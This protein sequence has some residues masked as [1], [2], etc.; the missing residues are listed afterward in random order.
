VRRGSGKVQIATC[1]RARH[2]TRPARHEE[3][4]L[5]EPRVCGDRAKVVLPSPEIKPTYKSRANAPGAEV[6]QVHGRFHQAKIQTV[7]AV[8]VGSQRSQ[9]GVK[10][11]LR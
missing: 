11:E 3:M 1:R 4:K 5:H 7:A 9:R 8:G 10:H 6:A 2:P